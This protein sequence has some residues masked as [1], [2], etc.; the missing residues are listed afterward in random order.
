MLAAWAAPAGAAI[1][2]VTETSDTLDGRCDAHCSLREAVVAANAAPGADRITLPA[3]VYGL[4]RAGAFEDAGATGDLDVTD[5]LAIVG[6]GAAATIIDAGRLDRAVHVVN[7]ALELSDLTIRN[8]ATSSVQNGAGVAAFGGGLSLTRVEIADNVGGGAGG[9]VYTGASD[10]TITDSTVAGN[11]A[12]RGGG[13]YFQGLTRQL[14]VRGSTVSGNRAE[15]AGGVFVDLECGFAGPCTVVST[16][17]AHNTGTDGA[18]GVQCVAPLGSLTLATTLLVGNTGGNCAPSS[19]RSE[20]HNLSDD[21]SCALDGPGDRSG[22]AGGLGALRWNGGPTRTQA[23]LAG[24]AAID[25]GDPAVCPPADQR[26]QAREGTCDIG[27]FEA[28]RGECG[29]AFVDLVETCELGA[30][31]PD[32]ECCLPTCAAAAPDTRCADDGNPCT[33]D[34]CDAAAG[35]GHLA[36]LAPACRAAVHSRLTLRG[37]GTVRWSWL[38]GAA[39]AASDLGTPQ[40]SSE[41]AY[42]LCVYGGA[43]PRL[44]A[45]VPVPASP[46]AWRTTSRQS[47]YYADTSARPGARKLLLRPGDT[48]RSRAEALAIAPAPALAG[49]TAPVVVQLHNNV[50]GVCWESR[51]EAEDLLR[52]DA[53][54]LR[55]VSDSL[56][57]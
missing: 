1:F 21:D 56:R 15:Q 35:C 27:A 16:T 20:G 57:D 39:I 12:A 9:G 36:A 51:F 40:S 34:A 46:A 37:D 52:N 45:A 42:A 55:A 31:G 8:G 13:L 48:R 32:G 19:A 38:H 50:P 49:V 44:L 7:T 24:S 5:A 25:A 26:G 17:I 6:N 23:V 18:G 43:T 29:D 4:T 30:G 22:Q 11:R 14:A 41:T 3:G 33:R 54:E 28:T 53:V 47:L 2:A 10:L